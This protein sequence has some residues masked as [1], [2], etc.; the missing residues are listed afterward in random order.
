MIVKNAAGTL[1]ATWQSVAPLVD[2]WVLVDTG[3]DDGTPELAQSLY[4]AVV[5]L[6]EPWRDD[7]SAA[8]NASLAAASGDWILMVDADE[9]LS[10]QSLPVLAAL[11]ASAPV[12][13]L[14][15][16]LMQ[17]TPT[18]RGLYVTPIV[19]V[20]ARDPR[21]RFHGLVHEQ[22]YLN[23]G[24]RLRVETLFRTRLDNPLRPTQ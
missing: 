21:L 6:R 2:E 10:P 20:F 22:A 18:A 9:I 16:A 19:R 14:A 3:S 24:T 13:D 1:P 15:Y 17:F 11:F 7:F 12:P 8:R 5:L 4:P 23:D